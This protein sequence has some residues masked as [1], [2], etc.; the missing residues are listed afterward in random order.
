MSKRTLF[1]PTKVAPAE[2]HEVVE[3]VEDAKD[4]PARIGGFYGGVNNYTSP[5]KPHC[6][7]GNAS[8]ELLG[9]R[10]KKQSW[11][12]IGGRSP[13]PV[14]VYKPVKRKKKGGKIIHEIKA[15]KRI[16]YE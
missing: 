7:L 15:V 11:D 8:I 1:R 9:S 2:E 10:P 12:F 14:T 4:H 3:E 6:T 13:G 5:R 16:T